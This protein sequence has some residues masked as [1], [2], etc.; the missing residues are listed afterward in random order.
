MI[1][2]VRGALPVIKQA[3]TRAGSLRFAPD[4]QAS[5]AVRKPLASLCLLFAW[6]CANGALLDG[7]QVFAWAKMFAGYAQS[8]PVRVALRETFDPAKPCEMC[9]GVAHAK[10]TAREQQP[11]AVERSAEKILLALHAASPFVFEICPV[12]WP[13][14]AAFAGP[15][16]V[17]TVPV[18]PPR[19]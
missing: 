3:T 7:V 6:F 4:A 11:Q 17:E 15:M 14:A 9:V 13:N 16:R 10:E 19:A 8:M 18:P 5:L 12:D 2:V 1:A